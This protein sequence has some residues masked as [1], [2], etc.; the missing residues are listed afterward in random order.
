MFLDMLGE[1]YSHISDNPD[2]LL[3]RFYGAYT[4][5]MYGVSGAAKEYQLVIMGN[6]LLTELPI[7]VKYDLKGSTSKRL[8]SND[9]I[10]GK[11]VGVRFNKLMDS[12]CTMLSL[13]SFF[14]VRSDELH[15]ALSPLMTLTGAN[16]V[17]CCLV[18]CRY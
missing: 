5:K 15:R 16:G 9:E 4:L 12:Y 8:V 17:V 14:I 1:Y 7:H 10:T 3:C 13:K 6:A 18:F 2:T 11:A